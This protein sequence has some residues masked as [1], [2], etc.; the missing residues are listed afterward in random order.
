[1][2]VEWFDFSPA[3]YQPEKYIALVASLSHGRTPEEVD[4][5]KLTQKLIS[6]GHES[7]FEFIRYPHPYNNARKSGLLPRDKFPIEDTEYL[8]RETYGT[9]KLTVPIYVARQIMRHRSFAYLELSRRYVKPPRVDVNFIVPASP[10]IALTEKLYWKAYNYSKQIYSTL[11]NKF[12]EAAQHA[13]AVLP[14]GMITAF[15]M[16]GDYKAW[17]N[18]FVYRLHPAAQIETRNV[19]QEIFY[20][21]KR[22]QFVFWDR[23]RNYVLNKWVDEAPEMFREGRK[24]HLEKV[25]EYFEENSK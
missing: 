25:R 15:W 14:L 18:F 7:V 20:S 13:R 16:Q 5:V 1:M 6:L 3:F 4:A 19:A 12:K 10:K 9:V 11:L 8:L 22:H 23:M 17:G 2:K 21:F 24:R